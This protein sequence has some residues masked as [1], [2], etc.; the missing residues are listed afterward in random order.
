MRAALRRALDRFT[1]A[2]LILGRR[3]TFTVGIAT[4]GPDGMRYE[5]LLEAADRDMY[6]C[7]FERYEGVLE[8]V[9]AS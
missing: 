1:D 5:S 7:K 8:G 6:R 9:R 3:A 4:L 2:T